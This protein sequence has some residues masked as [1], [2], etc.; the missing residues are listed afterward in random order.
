MKLGKSFDKYFEN[1]EQAKI[2][3]EIY[4]TLI[5]IDEIHSFN[6]K[7]DDGLSVRKIIFTVLEDDKH[8]FYMP[9]SFVN[10]ISDKII[11]DINNGNDNISGVF[12]KVTT[13]KGYQCWNFEDK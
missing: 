13:K 12:T 1:R 11:D 2:I 9:D 5:N 8:Y 7:D 4:D 10:E 6:M 3:D